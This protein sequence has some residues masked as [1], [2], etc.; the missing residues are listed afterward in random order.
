MV[1][2]LEGEIRV[3]AVAQELRDMDEALK[4]LEYNLLKAQ[5]QMKRYTD[6]KRKDVHFSEG[7]WVFL[8]LRPY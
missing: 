3:E 4:Q 5:E 2:F 8:K 1:Q 7:D 6:K